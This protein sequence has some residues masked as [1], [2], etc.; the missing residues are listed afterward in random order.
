MLLTPDRTLSRL[1]RLCREATD[2]RGLMR[3]AG[4]LLAEATASDSFVML[5]LDPLS[6]LVMDAQQRD[7]VE[8]RCAAFYDK[9]FLRTSLGDFGQMASARQRSV[10]V[11]ETSEKEYVDHV[12][13]PFGYRGELLVNL[14]QDSFAYGQ[15]FLSRRS[16]AFDHEERAFTDQ[17]AAPLAAA[18]RRL[19][20]EETIQ[21]TPGNAVALI[22]VDQQGRMTPASEHARDLL[23]NLHGPGMPE[24]GTALEG[25]ARL[26]ARD[27][28]GEWGR[29][30]PSG[31]FFDPVHRQRYR[32]VAERMLGEHPQA[33][34]VVE[35]VRALDSVEMLRHAGLTE[36]EADVALATL[37][38][39]T[40]A[41]GALSLR[42]SEHTFLSH[43][44]NVYRKLGV[45]SRGELAALLLGGGH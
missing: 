12:M 21:A 16:E 26:V 3:D 31:V 28:R 39:L 32:M 13:R 9:A 6:T 33:M 43:L 18:L 35:P 15:L 17:A 14:A 1:E 44:K 45:G 40:S 29:P 8:T 11:D 30:L 24:N 22:F 25:M 19:L 37:R 34:L 4:E 42:I 36:R 10:L 27:L 2:A 23:R 5:R 41:R 38:G 7:D 20:A